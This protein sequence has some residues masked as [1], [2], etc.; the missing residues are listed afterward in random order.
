MNKT[1]VTTLTNTHKPVTVNVSG[2]KY[3]SDG[4]DRDGIRPETVTV[5][6]L[7]DGKPV[8]GKK[9][10]VGAAENWTW[11]FDELP[12]YEAGR[13]ITYSIEESPVDG[14]TPA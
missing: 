2:I 3:W 5:Q 7:A 12:R 14:Y 1:T 4:N 10:T 11:K 13:E 8:E 9:I 6:L